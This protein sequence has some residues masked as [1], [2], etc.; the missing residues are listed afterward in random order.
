MS[1]IF[2]LKRG[3]TILPLSI[4]VA[5]WILGLPCLAQSASDGYDPEARIEE[6]DLLLPE[7]PPSIANYVR[8]VR[9]GNLVF[10]AGHGPLQSDGT[11]LSGKLG[12]DLDVEQ[13]YE[14]ARLTAIALLSSLKSEIGD[15]SRVRRIV[16]V[17]GMVN[18]TPEF[19]DQSQV[20]NGCSDL[21]V[22]IF[23]DRGRHARA[24]VGMAS[25]PRGFAVE[26]EMIVE[27]E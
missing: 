18:S 14:A 8:T 3:R 19:V 12:A 15:L 26:I 10:T 1:W 7:I 2:L 4:F 5:L 21:L 27:V 6:L 22:E 17:T 16:K 11:Y 9:T 24:A 23:G 25:L 20:V 13:G